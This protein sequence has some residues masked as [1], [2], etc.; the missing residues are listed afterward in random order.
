ME[1]IM[2]PH[3]KLPSKRVS[4]KSKNSGDEIIGEKFCECLCGTKIILKKRHE[5]TG[6]PRFCRGHAK[7]K[8]PAKQLPDRE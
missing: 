7:R 5:K 4:N 8:I 2:Q 6:I 3:L 1:A